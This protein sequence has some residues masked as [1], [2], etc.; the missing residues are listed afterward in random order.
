MGTDGRIADFTF[1]A[2]GG[3][4][5]RVSN[6]FR[7]WPSYLYL[8]LNR[9][10]IRRP[11]FSHL[12]A[13]S[14]RQRLAAFT[15]PM[16]RDA[17]SKRI[18]A[19]FADT[20]CIKIDRQQV[21]QLF[22]AGIHDACDRALAILK[23]LGSSLIESDA[24]LITFPELYARGLA[25]A[26]LAAAQACLGL[27]CLY[28]GATLKCERADGRVVGT[29]QWHLDIEDEKLFRVLLY[30]S[31]VGPGGGPFEC[32]SRADSRAIKAKL[33]YASGYVS[34]AK[35]AKAAGNLSFQQYTGGAGDAVLFDGAGIFHRGRT[36]LAQDRFSITFAYCSTVPLELHATARLTVPV[37]N[38]FVANLSEE[39]RR[40]IPCPRSR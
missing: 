3:F 37:H 32:F 35:M 28:L 33:R 38:G 24:A 39:Q 1:R 34:D 13:R 10:I 4:A 27:D 12:R 14:Y 22:G 6:I 29:R 36:P 40:A 26:V 21:P 17:L 9:R 18:V 19:A 7:A 5:L 31:P 20:G 15:T 11:P 30:L 2:S 16:V 25:P 23:T 8:H